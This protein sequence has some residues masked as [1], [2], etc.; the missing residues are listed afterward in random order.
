[1]VF[2]R[3]LQMGLV[4]FNLFLSDLDSAAECTFSK[5]V[6]DTNFCDEVNP[7]K[8]RDAIQRDLDKLQSSVCTKLMKISKVMS[9]DIHMGQ[10]CPKHKCKQSGECT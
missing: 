8:R 3:G 1:M 2:F 5:S 7:I 4:L 6:G 10:D 9:K